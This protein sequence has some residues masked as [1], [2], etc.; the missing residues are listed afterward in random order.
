M[1]ESD[2]FVLDCCW[3]KHQMELT[4]RVVRWLLSSR[5]VTRSNLLAT[6]E[7]VEMMLTLLLECVCEFSEYCR[8]WACCSFRFRYVAYSLG[9]FIESLV[10]AR[11]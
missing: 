3:K 4:W 5:S 8:C 10:V 6:E 2:T 7:R 1:C 11:P 9:L